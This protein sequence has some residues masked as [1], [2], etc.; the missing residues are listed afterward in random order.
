M[1]VKSFEN[2]G[3]KISEYIVKQKL[4]Q[5]IKPLLYNHL[6]YICAEGINLR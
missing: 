2:N 3:K 5:N 1:S 4:E 6:A